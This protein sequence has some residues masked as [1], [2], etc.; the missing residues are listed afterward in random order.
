MRDRTYREFEDAAQAERGTLRRLGRGA[1]FARSP[2]GR[3][4]RRAVVLVLLSAMCMVPGLAAADPIA[5]RGSMGIWSHGGDAPGI[6]DPLLEFLF[7]FTPEPGQ[8]PG[9]DSMWGEA[10]GT[11]PIHGS[12]GGL[13][14][15]RPAAATA[16]LSAGALVDVSTSITW[17]R[18]RLDDSVILGCCFD[19]VRYVTSG[20]L[21]MTAGNALLELQGN[22]LVGHAPFRFTGI[23]TASDALTGA[24]MFER[25]LRGRGEATFYSVA[26]QPDHFAYIY[27]VAPIPEPATLLLLGSGLA[28]LAVKGRRRWLH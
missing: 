23:V 14:L 20:A 7:Y 12:L 17:T 10:Y 9:V 27:D 19:S 26:G 2:A 1:L 8:L 21:A 18:G 25:R 15:T 4:P 16:D 11:S 3:A 13:Q 5:V 24:P 6:P 22:Q 28:G